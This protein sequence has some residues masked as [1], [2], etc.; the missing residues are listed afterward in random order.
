MLITRFLSVILVGFTVLALPSR[1][2]GEFNLFR[3]LFNNTI[4]TFPKVRTTPLSSITNRHI[5]QSFHVFQFNCYSYFRHPIDFF[6]IKRKIQ[7][8]SA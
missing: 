7:F 5:K 2:Q 3:L 6:E 8:F 4:V 1:A